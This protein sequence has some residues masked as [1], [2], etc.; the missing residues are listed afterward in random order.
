[1][2][3]AV[4]N[5]KVYFGLYT[6]SGIYD[7]KSQRFGDGICLRPQVDGARWTYSVGPTLADILI[8]IPTIPHMLKEELFIVF[9][10][11]LPLYAKTG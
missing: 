11:E 4:Q 5:C 8:S 2:V 9:M 10:I 7:K 6:S 3:Y 1:M